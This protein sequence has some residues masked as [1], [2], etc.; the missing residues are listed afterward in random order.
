MGLIIRRAKEDDEDDEGSDEIDGMHRKGNETTKQE[1][2]VK[3]EISTQGLT[4]HNRVD[5][6]L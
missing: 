6:L 5:T 3:D 1:G 4:K 2:K